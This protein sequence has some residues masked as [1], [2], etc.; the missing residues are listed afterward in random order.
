[1][2]DRASLSWEDLVMLHRESGKEDDDGGSDDDGDDVDD[3]GDDGNDG[4][5]SWMPMMVIEV[6][7]GGG[8]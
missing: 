8:G 4:G 7:K 2:R 1:M 6:D 5:G 3:G